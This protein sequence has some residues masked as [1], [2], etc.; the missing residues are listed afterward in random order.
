MLHYFQRVCLVLSSLFVHSFTFC[1][2]S[3]QLEEERHLWLLST[4]CSL[5]FWYIGAYLKLNDPTKPGVLAGPGGKAAIAMMYIWIASFILAWSGGPFVVGSEVFDQ[6]IRSLFAYK[7]R[8]VMGADLYHVKIHNQHDSC[9]GLWYLFLFR[10]F[11]SGHHPISFLLL[12]RNKRYCLG[13]Y[14]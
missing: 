12:A 2:L 6:N 10:C 9:H 11:G 7:C 8:Y 4:V 13:R 14:G 1:L 3:T 5:C